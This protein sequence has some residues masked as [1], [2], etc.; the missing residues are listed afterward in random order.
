MTEKK[1]RYVYYGL[2][3]IGILLYY[4]PHFILGQDASFRISDF[5]DDEVVQY[6]LNG[7][8]LFASSDTIVKEWLS[9][10]PLATIQAPCFLLILFFKW[11]PFY[12]AL[13]LSSIFGTVVAF[14]GMFLLCDELLQGK[15]RY[16]SY[17]AAI[18]FCI[19]P[20]YPSYGLSS[21]GLPL[22]V[23]ACIRLC[24]Q[25]REKKVGKDIP[26]YLLLLLYALSS[27]MIWSGYFVVGFMIVAAIIRLIQKKK[28]WIKLFCA[29]LGMTIIYVLVFWN[30]IVSVFFG[31]FTSHRSDPDRIYVAEEFGQ[32]FIQLFKYGQYHVPSLH[33]YIMALALAV[34]ILGWL[35]Y[36]KL[37]AHQRKKVWLVSGIWISA[38][39]IAVFYAFY[40]CEIGLTL[41][42][43]WGGLQSFQFDRIYWAYPML[44][45]VELALSVSL[46][47]DIAE[48]IFDEICLH[49]AV[50]QKKITPSIKQKVFGCAKVL[51]ML[52]ITVF[53]V[54]YIIHHINS[55]EYYANIQKVFGQESDQMSYREFYDHELFEEVKTYIGKDQ[56]TYRVGCVGF[57]PAIASVNGFYTVDAYSTNYPLDYKRTFRKVIEKELEK[58]EVLK[59]YYDNWGSRCYLFSAELG[60]QFQVR[61]EEQKVLQQFEIDTDA[62]KELGCNY[63]LSAVKIANAT[64]IQL[65]FLEQFTTP[66]S[67]IEIFVYELK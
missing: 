57:V 8:Y 35:W 15:Q 39:F 19:L 21:V 25:K 36:R 26:Y 4:L 59:S 12:Q 6:L 29:A 23:W 37:Q 5:M 31:T 32:K 47:F 64:D 46:L 3:L 52:V 34:A 24:S 16:F 7:N 17:M 60:M 22:V 20:Y 44:W 33:T 63:I 58:N 10:A 27:S 66:E 45:Y 62:L 1:N 67:A 38:L 54:N 65:E 51:G 55:V 13:L 11:L 42:G 9:G 43:Y 49:A 28:D 61:K 41:R 53:F 48:S 56:S 50:L 14:F 2:G 40:S 30:T 18:L